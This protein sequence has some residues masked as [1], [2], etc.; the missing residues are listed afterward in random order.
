MT[1]DSTTSLE[2]SSIRTQD[3][4]IFTSFLEPMRV[5]PQPS[6]S[7]PTKNQ[8]VIK[9]PLRQKKRI[10]Q[11]PNSLLL[12]KRTKQRH[13]S[14]VSDTE[15]TSIPSDLLQK[16]PED[17]EICWQNV[18][19]NK[20]ND[21]MLAYPEYCYYPNM[22]IFSDHKMEATDSNQFRNMLPGAQ[23]NDN[24]C[25]ISSEYI[26]MEHLDMSFPWNYDHFEYPAHRVLPSIF[27]KDDDNHY[28][29]NTQLQ[30]PQ[31]EEINSILHPYQDN[32]YPN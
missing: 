12:C 7:K 21:Y 4:F 23:T 14:K 20:P 10:H 28:I 6:K 27:P 17:S 16:E 29:I 3:K 11:P 25:A 18:T 9:V 19:N 2:N 15:I 8:Q 32:T 26:T 13:Y 1:I 5:N 31:S 22:K 24:I 30:L